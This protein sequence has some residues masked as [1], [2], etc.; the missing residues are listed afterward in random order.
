LFRTR[1]VHVFFSKLLKGAIFVVKKQLPCF[2]KNYDVTFHTDLPDI[3]LFEV[4][5]IRPDIRPS[6]PVS[7]QILDLKKGRIIRPT[8][9]PVN[10]YFSPVM[11]PAKSYGFG[12]TAPIE[13]FIRLT[14]EAKL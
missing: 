7:G 11:D 6:N 5:G 9:Y 10:P 2:D 1:F 12:S 14:I 13:N 8:G 3:R 4:S